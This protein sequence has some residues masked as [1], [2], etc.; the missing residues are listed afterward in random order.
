[1][2][3]HGVLPAVL[4]ATL[5]TGSPALAQAV[6]QGAAEARQAQDATSSRFELTVPN[7]MRGPE[8][9]GEG[10]SNVQWTDDGRW[11][12]FRWKP[13][14]EPWHASMS[15]YRVPASG[16]EPVRLT[17]DQADSVSVYLSSGDVSADGRW[18]VVSHQ[19]D[20]HIIDRRNMNVRRLTDTRASKS[21]PVFSRDARTVYFISD[22]N[23][24]AHS[25]D[26]GTLRQIT[27][28]RSGPAPS[29]PREP[30]GQRRFLVDQQRELFEHIRV[31]AERREQQQARMRARQ[32]RDRQPI[33]LN[34]D[35]R[36]AS[37]AIEPG[38]RYAV[39]STASTT[40]SGARRVQIPFWVT[41]SG[42]VEARE[43]RTHVGDNQGEGGRMGIVSLDDGAIRWLDVAAATAAGTEAPEF[44]FTRFLGWNDQGTA[45][46]V[47]AQS[48]DFKNA[49][50]WSMD[51]ATGAMTLLAHDQD[52]AWVA[53]PCP[54]WQ[55][56]N[57]V[58][59][60]PD[61]RVWFVSERTGY[62]HLYTSNAD[63]SNLR[64]LT[65]GDW[66]VHGVELSPRRDRFFLTTNEGSPHHQHFWSMNLDGSNRTRIT[67]MPGRQQVTVSPDGSTLAFVHSFANVPPELFIA[68]NRAGAQARQVTNSPTTEWASYE[69][70]VPEI[71]NITA[72]DG[73]A[74]PARI[75]RPED[76]GAHPN[77]AAVIFVH[78]AGY[79][80]NVHNWWSQYYREYMFHHLLAERGYVVLDMDYRA[81]AG[82]G[83]DWRTAIYRHMGGWDLSDHVDGSRW[84]QR[85]FG[86]DPERIGIY[87]GSYGG[88]ITLM[89]LF[90]EPQDFGAGAALRAVTDWAHYNHGYTGR[91][92]NLP[93]DDEE[94]YRQSSPIYFAE[95]LE[96]PLL[97]T[98]GMVDVNVHFSDVV[99]LA[100]RL[101]ELGKT[102]W[103]MAVYPVEDHGFVE[104]S[105]WADQYRRILE[106]FERNIG[107]RATA[108]Q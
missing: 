35:E 78:G 56:S 5:M 24:F 46:L 58:G 87:G 23:L 52:S 69:W 9:V 63:G 49:W 75:Y 84:L 18:R 4:L 74:V 64:Q 13:G 73:K 12:Y 47:S 48:A 41:E 44:G 40:P 91:I 3:R 103:E 34:R 14:G 59:F 70:I 17:D 83:R 50:L 93:Q 39:V 33:Y 25:L 42:Y 30:Q 38:G 67:T 94:A 55:R 19:G 22:N 32:E 101:I 85:E 11:I 36:V 31:Q 72:R 98:H 89:A 95:G 96:D 28:V 26:D 61:G 10:P 80:Q 99:R 62:T 16:G 86:I 29:D 7:I 53:G 45:G 97:I 71:V 54:F 100:Q 66:E 81:S 37:L 6:A 102:D 20:I 90:N 68:P 1:M 88:F 51:A 108:Q 76:V 105:S 57:C 82:Y 43:F 107:G 21:S 106:L 104:P 65:S 15:L 79:L 60:L 27:D 92:L 77:G 8:L 2:I